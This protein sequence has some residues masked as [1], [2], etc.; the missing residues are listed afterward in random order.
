MRKR[1]GK[2]GPID[3]PSIL[4]RSDW[5]LKISRPGE[6]QPQPF[7]FRV[8]PTAI[9]AYIE[10]VSHA[11]SCP[12]DYVAIPCLAALATA[13]GT[14]RR[15]QVKPGW[16][17]PAVLYAAIVGEPGSAKSPALRKGM[18]PVERIQKQH[19]DRHIHDSL[20]RQSQLKEYHAKLAEWKRKKPLKG[21]PPNEPKPLRPPAQILSTDATI[22]ALGPVLQHR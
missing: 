21:K 10:E 16:Q 22:E 17:E 1:R 5:G 14:Q 9:A 8:L 7:P 13:I 11:L 18:D 19:R 15:L 2:L 4:E 20:D 3:W 6:I 12:Q